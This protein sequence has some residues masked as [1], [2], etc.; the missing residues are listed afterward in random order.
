[1]SEANWIE[2]AAVGEIEE[3]DAKQV[4]IGGACLAIFNVAG[5]YHATSDICTHALAYLSQGYIEGGTV[6]CPLHQ[7]RFDIA[8]GRAL[9]PPVTKNLAT[10]PVRVEGDRILVQLPAPE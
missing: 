9:S 7:G 2:V 3:D 8:S 5:A 4:R 1:V 6:E 10:Y